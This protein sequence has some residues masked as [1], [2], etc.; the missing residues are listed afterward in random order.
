MEQVD[1]QG[2]TETRAGQDHDGFSQS[3]EA[4]GQHVLL[5]RLVAGEKVSAEL[6]DE[7]RRV[8]PVARRR[9]TTRSDGRAGSLRA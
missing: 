6:L 2:D 8:A 5:R 4:T 9:S 3:R 7:A 1:E